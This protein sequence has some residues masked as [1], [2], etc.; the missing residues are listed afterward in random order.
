MNN[1]AYNYVESTKSSK[2]SDIANWRGRLRN[3]TLVE[4]AKYIFFSLLS[5]EG[6]LNDGW[7]PS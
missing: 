1:L 4:Q 5:G 3:G 2:I 7:G 6:A